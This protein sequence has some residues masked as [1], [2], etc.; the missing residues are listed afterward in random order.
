[1]AG[2]LLATLPKSDLLEVLDLVF[3]DDRADLPP[4][5]LIK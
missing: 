1:V 5:E 4:D 3:Q 2:F